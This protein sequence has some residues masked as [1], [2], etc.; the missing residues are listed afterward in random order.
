MPLRI[1]A[2]AVIWLAAIL[3]LGLGWWSD[4]AALVRVAGHQSLEFVLVAVATHVIAAASIVGGALYFLNVAAAR[5]IA[6]SAAICWLA[7]AAVLGGGMT[8]PLAIV[9]VL[10]MISGGTGFLLTTVGARLQTQLQPRIPSRARAPEQNDERRYGSI[11]GVEDHSKPFVPPSSWPIPTVDLPTPQARER[12]SRKTGPRDRNHRRARTREI[13]AG[14]FAL[15]VILIGGAFFGY[16]VWSMAEPRAAVSD[17]GSV[18]KSPSKPTPPSKTEAASQLAAGS[19]PPA[20]SRVAALPSLPL[21]FAPSVAAQ[22]SSKIGEPA[23]NEPSA[24]SA[25]AASTTDVASFSSPQDYCAAA[26][27]VDTPDLARLSGGVQDLFVKARAAA[28]LTQGDVHWR[29]MDGAVWVCATSTGGLACDKVPTSVDRVLICAAH[30]DAKGIRTAAGDWSCD[31]F[32]P[33]VTPAQLQAPD[34]R[35]FD[36]S[37]WH[38]LADVG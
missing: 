35:G 10:S 25:A 9:T 30:P 19:E 5:M 16:I 22:E 38:K 37:V 24:S 4:P 31:G 6:L 11:E 3:S 36:R 29:C 2:A 28:K 13:V 1:L 26:T 8:W 7:M 15:V 33:V 18:P 21:A 27:N 32:T 12:S 14:A 20:S 17:L 34:R 23:S